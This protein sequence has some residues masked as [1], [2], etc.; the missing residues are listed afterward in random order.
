MTS[1]GNSESLIENTLN[2]GAEPSSGRQSAGNGY[3]P[4]LSSDVQSPS[5]IKG[6]ITP[7]AASVSITLDDVGRIFTTAKGS[8][9]ALQHVSFEVREGEFVAVVGPSGCGKST[10]L[11]MI[12]GLALPDEGSVKVLGKKVTSLQREVGFIFQRDALLPWRTALQNVAL[13]LRFRGSDRKSANEV[14]RSWL[15][16][17]GLQKFESYYPHQL[18]GGMRKRVAVAA[19]LAYEPPILLMDEP[20]SAL[21]V[22]TR[23]I[24]END[25][26]R[27]WQVSKPTVIFITHDLQEAVGIADRVIVMS[28]G[29]GTVIG[30]YEVDL[31]RPRDLLEL[32]YN[33]HFVELQQ[34]IWGQLR[35][36]V[37]KAQD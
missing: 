26:L 22:E 10:L 24:M 3:D 7:S 29:P 2:A 14:A 15:A 30:D 34:K 31:G 13:P 8:H 32:R 25:L 17:I 4:R 1:Y 33:D 35:E 18:S 19:T 21:D 23:N 27:L 36:E 5:G 6:D 28:A 37:M 16:Q 9:T 20:F 12:S 11:S